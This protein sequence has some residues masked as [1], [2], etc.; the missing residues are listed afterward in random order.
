MRLLVVVPSP[1]DHCYDYCHLWAPDLS[2]RNGVYWIYFSAYRV[3]DVTI[4]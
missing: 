4:P 3:V 2:K 1:V